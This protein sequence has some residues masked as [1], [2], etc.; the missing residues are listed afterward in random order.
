MSACTPMVTPMI[1]TVVKP[2]K[3]FSSST[4]R[5]D[6]SDGTASTVP[7][8]CSCAWPNSAAP[9]ANSVSARSQSVSVRT[10]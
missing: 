2:E 7:I 6:S 4:N 9:W 3:K 10:V 8:I 1:D 5:N